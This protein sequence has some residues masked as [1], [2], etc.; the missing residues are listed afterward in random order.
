M[1]SGRASIERIDQQRRDGHTESA[2]AAG[3]KAA[4][5]TLMMQVRLL[6]VASRGLDLCSITGKVFS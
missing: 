4:D 2:P 1:L 6:P 5:E 3:A